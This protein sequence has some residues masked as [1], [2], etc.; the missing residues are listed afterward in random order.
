MG[1]RNVNC[2]TKFDPGGVRNVKKFEK[3][4]CYLHFSHFSQIHISPVRNVSHSVRNRD[5]VGIKKP[6]VW[7]VEKNASNG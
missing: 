3:S 4:H 6:C 1:V 5:R 2:E 7:Q